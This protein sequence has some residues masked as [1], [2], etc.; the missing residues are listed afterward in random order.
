M[1]ATDAYRKQ[2]S[3]LLAL[4]AKLADALDPAKLGR[5]ATP[6]RLILSNLSGKLKVHLAMEDNSLY[7]RMLQDSDP[8]V[9]AM[10][11]RFAD[12]MG[13]IAKA[14]GGYVE[15]WPSANAIQLAPQQFIDETR[16]IFAALAS[17][18]E[19]ENNQL[20]PLLDQR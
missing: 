9:S 5:D 7:P 15:R 11:R 2:H 20:Y 8:A 13:G 4:A 12:E 17:R 10:A 14:F 18:I 19:R 6:A 3:E 1:A 16:K